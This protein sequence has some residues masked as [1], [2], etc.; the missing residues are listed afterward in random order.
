MNRCGVT[1]RSTKHATAA[2]AA[3]PA[4]AGAGRFARARVP[5]AFAWSVAHHSEAAWWIAYPARVWRA[6]APSAASAGRSQSQWLMAFTGAA[7]ARFWRAPAS[8]SAA[9]DRR[10]ATAPEIAPSRRACFHVLMHPLY[11]GRACCA[12]QPLKA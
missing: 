1:T 11:A 6:L 4:S 10:L 7:G 3:A 2:A 8:T 9:A 12:A 5:Q